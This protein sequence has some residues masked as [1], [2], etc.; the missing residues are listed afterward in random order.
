MFAPGSRSDVENL[1]PLL[2]YNAVPAAVVHL[3]G[4]LRMKT[5]ATLRARLPFHLGCPNAKEVTRDGGSRCP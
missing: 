5:P 4:M 2:Q 1:A 3:A